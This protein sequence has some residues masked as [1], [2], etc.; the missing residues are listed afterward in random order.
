MIQRFSFKE[1]IKGLKFKKVYGGPPLNMIH[2]RNLMIKINENDQ[3]SK[4]YKIYGT[5]LRHFIFRR[6]N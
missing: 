4:R 5:K 1:K 2:L 6:P 3:N